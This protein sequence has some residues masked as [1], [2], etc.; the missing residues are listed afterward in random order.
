[1]ALAAA[2]GH[3]WDLIEVVPQPEESLDM[4]Y[5]WVEDW[6][7]TWAGIRS[8]WKCI[9][10]NGITI[11]K[12]HD[13]CMHEY[14]EESA[15]CQNLLV[16]G[17]IAITDLWCPVEQRWTHINDIFE[18]Y[19]ERV[20]LRAQLE[21]ERLT[22]EPSMHT[23]RQAATTTGEGQ[24]CMPSTTEAGESSRGTGQ[25]VRQQMDSTGKGKGKEK[26]TDKVNKLEDNE[27]ECPPNP[28]PSKTGTPAPKANLQ[29]RECMKVKQKCSWLLRVG[30][31]CKN[32]GS[33]E[34][35]AGLSHKWTKSVTVMAM[36]E[37]PAMTGL[38]LRMPAHKPP[39][40]Q[41]SKLSPKHSTPCASPPATSNMPPPP[42]FLPSA[43]PAP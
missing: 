21:A 25:P 31:K 2:L 24:G 16:L 4:I 18:D 11:L 10:D 20:E 34:T 6:D 29:C 3:I 1:M 36:T 17:A 28:D 26:A 5:T 8:W 30:R 27:G 13:E 14:T 43:T 33:G 40:R 39:P 9:D 19:Q 15:M 37:T 38:K 42:L 22:R 35:A 7:K 32:A 23:H 12:V 41:N